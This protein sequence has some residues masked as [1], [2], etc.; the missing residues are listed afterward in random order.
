MRSTLETLSA[1]VIVVAAI[2]PVGF[3]LN[4]RLGVYWAV[5]GAVVW[6]V[7]FAYAAA[8]VRKSALGWGVIG[9]L[10]CGMAWALAEIP[11]HHILYFIASLPTDSLLG[12]LVA[13]FM[14]AFWG[15]AAGLGAGLIVGASF[16]AP[17]ESEIDGTLG[18]TALIIGT[19]W[20]ALAG[21]A[22]AMAKPG[23]SVV[24]LGL[25]LILASAAGYST[26]SIGRRIGQWFRPSVMFFDE[27]WP[28]LREMAM[29]LAGFAVGYVA[30][31]LAFAGFYSTAW[32]IG[33]EA[34]TG[35]PDNP[36]FWDF[37]YFSLMTATTAN[38]EVIPMSRITQA[39]AS[40]EVVL[41][42]GWLVVI[43]GALS[44]HLAPRLEAIAARVHGSSR[45]RA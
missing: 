42:T 15:V 13:T 7:M 34:F 3:G 39:M 29:P 25:W 37:V 23:A 38:T 12:V 4:A 26:T 6:T 36:N 1:I 20:G 27:L 16:G 9:G 40:I 28:Y 43:F 24:L 30:L 31:T 35:L 21:I 22:V 19:A 10:I 32:R 2:A 33:A 18:K 41:G 11:G 17:K 14:S 45:N 44:V 5:G 8:R